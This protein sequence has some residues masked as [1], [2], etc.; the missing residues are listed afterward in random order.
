MPTEI[1]MVANK[2]NQSFTMCFVKSSAE[3]TWPTLLE[4]IKE[5]L[6]QRGPLGEDLD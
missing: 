5:K 6:D 1:K 2:Q 3:E 4:R